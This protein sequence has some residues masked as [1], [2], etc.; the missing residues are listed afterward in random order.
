MKCH[1]KGI[2][3]SAASERVTGKQQNNAVPTE[4]VLFARGNRCFD[5]PQRTIPFPTTPRLLLK[6]LLRRYIAPFRPTETDSPSVDSRRNRYA[7]L[8]SFAQV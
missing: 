5:F 4:T 3:L 6:C 2:N 8:Q 1:R 7:N